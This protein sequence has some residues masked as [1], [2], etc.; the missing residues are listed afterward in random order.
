RSEVMAV[1]A[2]IGAVESDLGKIVTKSINILDR[3][4]ALNQ[5]W[6]ISGNAGSSAENWVRLGIQPI[7]PSKQ[8]HYQGNGSIPSGAPLM[9]FF[10][11]EGNHIPANNILSTG[12]SNQDVDFTTS[13]SA[14]F[15]GAN[16]QN[17]TGVG[18]NP[19]T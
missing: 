8:Y 18:N 9:V 2:G 3:S 11:A 6:N 7:K 12:G 10:D 14:F 15:V 4:A 1:Q 17:A 16:V 13:D 19:L 5:A